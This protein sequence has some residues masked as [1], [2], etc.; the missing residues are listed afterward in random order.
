MSTTCRLK[1]YII[2]LPSIKEL[3]RTTRP[4]N[5]PSMMSSAP[6]RG[7]QRRSAPSRAAVSS[8]AS[9]PR[10][11]RGGSH[12]TL[13]T[14]WAWNTFMY[15]SVNYVS[16]CYC[17]MKFVAWGKKTWNDY[18]RVMLFSHHWKEGNYISFALFKW[19]FTFVYMGNKYNNSLHITRSQ[20]R[21][22]TIIG[23]SNERLITP[24]LS[25]FCPPVFTADVEKVL[26]CLKAPTFI[27]RQAPTLHLPCVYV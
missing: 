27:F 16:R 13:P 12:I 6:D 23:K 8:P 22:Q 7:H 14:R 11:W 10:T 3:T 5:S 15:L 20:W 26:C 25:E 2:V 18:V 17:M 24:A 21:Q 9:T 1:C 4:C 19:L